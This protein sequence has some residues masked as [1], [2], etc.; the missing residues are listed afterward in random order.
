MEKYTWEQMNYDPTMYWSVQS[1]FGYDSP[2]I[3][4]LEFNCPNFPP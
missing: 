3:T 1:I 2:N 4:T